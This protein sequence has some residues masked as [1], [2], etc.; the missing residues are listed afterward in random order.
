MITG[1][2]LFWLAVGL[3]VGAIISYAFLYLVALLV[4]RARKAHDK[5]VHVER[6]KKKDYK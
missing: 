4:G 3:F 5:T 1:T 2:H 6:N